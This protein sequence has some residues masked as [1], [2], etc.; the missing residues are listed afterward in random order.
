MIIYPVPVK[1]AFN[2][3]VHS[4]FTMDG[5]I[6]F[7]PTVFP[8]FSP[9]NYDYLQDVTIKGLLQQIRAYSYVISSP[10]ERARVGQ[11]LTKELYKSLFKIALLREGCRVQAVEND[12]TFKF[13]RAGIRPFLFNIE[14]L[15]LQN[16]W[17]IKADEG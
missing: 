6:K 7:G 1:G 14:S 17:V 5:R 13:Y 15:K 2:L 3:G 10:H 8:A 11:Y 12:L 16:D 4:T 9:T